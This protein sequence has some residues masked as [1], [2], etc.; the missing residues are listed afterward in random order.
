MPPIYTQTVAPTAEPYT[1]AQLLEYTRAT[2]EHGALVTSLAAVAREFVEEQTGRAMLSQT[3]KLNRD[4]WPCA[5]KAD[6][7]RIYLERTPLAT[8]TSVKYWPADGGAQA[9]LS[10]SVY[11]VINGGSNS[12]GFVELKEGQSW[13]DLACRSDAIEIIF[14]AG[15]ALAA[16]VKKQ[17]S[18]AVLLLTKHFYDNGQDPVNIGNIV[19]DVP[20]TLR[21]LIS[22]QRVGG[23]IA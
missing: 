21:D 22:S 17:V 18:H 15:V 19:N 5:S 23:W 4:K 8:V 7:N 9:T 14:T 3:W 20:F 16:N 2:P 1:Q 11:N 13:P 10:T 6:G 12:P